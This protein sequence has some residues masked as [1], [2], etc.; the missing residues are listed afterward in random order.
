MR[1]IAVVAILVVAL[2]SWGMVFAF[3][4]EPRGFRGVKWGDPPTED[5]VITRR[6]CEKYGRSEY[7]RIE[8]KMSLGNA[9]FTEIVYAFHYDQFMAV[10]LHFDGESNYQVLETICR[11]KFG[12][13]TQERYD[14][15][16]WMTVGKVAVMLDYDF[17][18]EKGTVVPTD[19]GLLTKSE[20]A[21]KNQESKDAKRDW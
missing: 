12:E 2:V 10:F 7:K 20:L 16:L 5:I 14:Q 13:P 15:F 18:K 11:N 3:Q 1:K 6:P 21:R 4:N 8:E 17:L 9:E 19:M